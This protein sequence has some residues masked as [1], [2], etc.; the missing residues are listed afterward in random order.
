MQFIMIKI[1]HEVSIQ[2]LAQLLFERFQDNIDLILIAWLFAL[3][4][5]LGSVKN[6]KDIT[7]HKEPF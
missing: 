5:E 7:E 1:I 3:M 4:T 6:K 2:S